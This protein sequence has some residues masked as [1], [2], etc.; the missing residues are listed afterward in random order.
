MR[1]WRPAAI[2][3]SIAAVGGLAVVSGIVPITASSGHWPITAS[4]LHFAM[5][6][7]V[8]THSLGQEVPSL[9]EPWLAQKGAAHYEAACRPCHGSP[10]H[11]RPVIAQ[12]MTPRPPDL[13]K[14]VREWKAA[15]L[16]YIVKHG[17]KLTGMPAWPAQQR[18]DEV[19]AMVA[20]LRQLPGLDAHGYRQLRDGTTSTAGQDT[21]A[22]RASDERSPG[23]AHTCERCHG[24][25]GRG[26]GSPAF[27]IL[28][29]QRPAYLLAALQAY[30]RDERHSGIMGPV[31]GNL[32]VEEMRQLAHYFGRLTRPANPRSAISD[33][34]ALERGEEIARRGIP[35]QRVPAC[36]ACHGPGTTPL[37]P[38]YPILAGQ[39]SEYLVLQLE[40][41]QA[42]RRGGSPYARL[43]RP[44]ASRLTREQ[45]QAVALYYES[46]E[47]LAT[48]GNPQ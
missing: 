17:V 35:S 33:A 40:L 19:W 5:R 12:H 39:Y 28:K 29:G 47:S 3:A 30:S 45:M 48:Q 1:R 32:H 38:S 14:A 20:F 24:R 16:F 46:L 37:N 43:M 11:P 2:A 26:L 4:F 6:R 41:I 34:A 18:D 42:D 10:E 25:D 13:S 31:A 15:E 23:I 9:D 36:V 22:D 8:A 27:P 21:R 44:V 7:S